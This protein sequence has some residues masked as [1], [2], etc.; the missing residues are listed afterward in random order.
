MVGDHH[1]HLNDRPPFPKRVTASKEAAIGE[2]E[3]NA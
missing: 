1:R 3:G 2:H